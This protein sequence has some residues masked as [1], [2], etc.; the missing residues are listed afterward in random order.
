MPFG[1]FGTARIHPSCV[2]AL[3]ASDFA[4]NE[5]R[6]PRRCVLICFNQVLRENFQRQM[7]GIDHVNFVIDLPRRFIVCLLSLVSWSETRKLKLSSKG[8]SLISPCFKAE[9]WGIDHV[10]SDLMAPFVRDNNTVPPAQ[11][12]VD[13][14]TIGKENK[15]GVNSPSPRDQWVV[16]DEATRQ[17]GGVAQH[18]FSTVADVT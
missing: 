18:Q 1:F 4:L 6:R 7:F 17:W 11:R 12:L 8:I 16:D 9:A 2:N 15:T 5:C 14:S 10:N 13:Y 3:R